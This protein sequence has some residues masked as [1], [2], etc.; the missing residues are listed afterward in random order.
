L[1]LAKGFNLFLG[2]Q[3]IVAEFFSGCD[4]TRTLGE[5]ISNFS[6]KVDAP[7]EQVQKECLDAVR[8]LIE[9]GF[10]LC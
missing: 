7:P 2:L 4:G 3:P 5:L 9:R 10:L 6:T 1:R 8:K